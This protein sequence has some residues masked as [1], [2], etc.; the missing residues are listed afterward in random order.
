MICWNLLLRPL[1]RD[2]NTWA[3]LSNTASAT[4]N[5]QHAIK[6]AGCKTPHV[7]TV[8]FKCVLNN[9]CCMK[10]MVC[11]AHKLLC[12]TPHFPKHTF[13]IYTTWNVQTHLKQLTRHTH[14]TYMQRFTKAQ[15]HSTSMLHVEHAATAVQ[16]HNSTCTCRDTVPNTIAL[17]HVLS[18]N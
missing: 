4:H 16:T 12:T 18:L 1:L 5:K 7:Y 17:D 2:S 14:S 9:P 15:Q 6:P 10:F 11:T 3:T 8:D 13:P